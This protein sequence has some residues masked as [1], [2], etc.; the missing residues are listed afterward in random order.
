MLSAN[1][2]DAPRRLVDVYVLS[3]LAVLPAHQRNGIGTQLV[4][5]AIGAAD[6]CG[7]PLVFLEGSRSQRTRFG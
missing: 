6:V 2:L 1:R 5:H 7:V 4:R 3:P